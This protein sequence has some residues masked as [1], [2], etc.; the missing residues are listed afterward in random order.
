[1][2]AFSYTALDKQDKIKKGIL[3]SDNA[4]QARQQ[5]RN[6]GLKPLEVNAVNVKPNKQTAQRGLFSPSLS[7]SDLSL[8]TRQLATLVRAALPLEESLQAV[9]QQSESTRVQMILMAVRS[10]ILAGSPLAQALETFPRIFKRD[11]IATVSAGEQ[12][13]DLAVV[14]E[15]LADH[16]ERDQELRQKIMGALLYPIILAIVAISVVIGLLVY[17]VP[18]I[19]K[20]FDSMNKELP[21]LTQ[22][23]IKISN[24]LQNQGIWILLSGLITAILIY[25]AL[26]NPM[27]K[28]QWH[29]LLLKLPMTSPLLRT[30]NSARF[31]R[32]LSTLLMSGV[33]MLNALTIAARVV[34]NIPMH[35]T[36]IQ[37]IQQ[38]RE[39][40]SLSKALR[41]GYGFTPLTIHLIAS[42]E[43]SGKL[44][45][46]LEKAS[47]TQEREL[48][49]WIANFLVLLEPLM[50][51][52]MGG[53]VL[54][55]VLAIMLPIFNL[56]QLAG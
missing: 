25:T 21:P 31:C 14:F 30:L 43:S 53:I 32:T 19:I 26:Q 7:A 49:N 34:T 10:E 52:V 24:L 38:V 8:L 50:L 55:I 56:N 13:G 46:M 35:N 22:G 33:P 27:I 41:Q 18:Q 1:M 42:G 5:L 40:S 11:Y 48:K 3:E 47:E 29:Q 36:V 39:G 6:Q 15:R 23:L 51:L 4:K 28:K 45:L 17:V 2:P 16:V 20:V 12:S 37:A 44:D 9:A 54:T